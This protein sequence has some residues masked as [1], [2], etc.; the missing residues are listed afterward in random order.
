MSIRS[1]YVPRTPAG[2]VG[3]VLFLALMALA[4]PPV[5]FW[6]DARVE[7]AWGLL[8]GHLVIYFA[9]IGVLTYTLSVRVWALGKRFGYNSYRGPWGCVTRLVRTTVGDDHLS[10]YFNPGPKRHAAFAAQLPDRRRPSC[11]STPGR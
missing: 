8:Y 4:Q 3:L 9:L 6:V 11:R 1:H 10:A 5:V 2:W 7:G